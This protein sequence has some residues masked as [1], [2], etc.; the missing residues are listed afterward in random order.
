MSPGQMVLAAG[1]PDGRVPW[2]SGVIPSAGKFH[3]RTRSAREGP[4]L[5]L[6]VRMGVFRSRGNRLSRGG[7]ALLLL[8]AI[9]L[10]TSATLLFLVEPMIAKMIL[11]LLGGTPAVWNTCMVFF[12]ALLLAGYLYAHLATQRLGVRRQAA[13]HLGVLLLPLATLPLLTLPLAISR[14]AT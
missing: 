4:S 9:T 7:A 8:F 2:R 1:R 11:P 13:V 3:R 6:R 10:F 5:A 14:N 12:Q